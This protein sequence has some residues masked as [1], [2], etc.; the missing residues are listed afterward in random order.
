MTEEEDT[1]YNTLLLLMASQQH[2]EQQNRALAK[3]HAALIPARDAIHHHFAGAWE[4]EHGRP[5]AELID[6]ALKAIVV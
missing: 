1:P 4:D 2:L 6:E 5:L 3:C